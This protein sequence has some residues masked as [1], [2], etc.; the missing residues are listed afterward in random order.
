MD[1][2]KTS[3]IVIW[4]P[5]LNHIGKNNFTTPLN[6]LQESRQTPSDHM[7]SNRPI[8]IVRSLIRSKWFPIFCKMIK[9]SFSFHWCEAEYVQ[10]LRVR[11]V[12]VSHLFVHK[13]F[14]VTRPPF[15]ILWATSS[16]M[17][18]T[19]GRRRRNGLKVS[20]PRADEGAAKSPAWKTTY[21]F[22]F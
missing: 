11:H 18:M 2:W 12:H 1:C 17:W 20:S 6:T 5:V 22:M 3:D 15:S 7:W 16:H 19:G 21:C 4:I 9:A 13:R 10:A 14:K 8:N